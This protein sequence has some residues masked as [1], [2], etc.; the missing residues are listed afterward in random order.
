MK[1]VNNFLFPLGMVGV[2]FYLAHT[3]T[4]RILWKGYN[5]ITTDI[6]SLTAD[7][8]PAPSNNLL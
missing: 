6:S 3:I 2:L 8:A 7:G 5:P 1:K 4:G